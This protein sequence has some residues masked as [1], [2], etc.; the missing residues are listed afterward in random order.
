[1]ESQ[2]SL[3]AWKPKL[4]IKLNMRSFFCP[5]FCATACLLLTISPLEI[6][7]SVAKWVWSSWPC[8]HINPMLNYQLRMLSV[9]WALPSPSSWEHMQIVL[10]RH[11]RCWQQSLGFE[12]DGNIISSVPHVAPQ[13]IILDRDALKGG[14]VLLSISQAGP[15]RNFMQP[16]THLDSDSGLCCDSIP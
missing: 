10:I 15:G 12:M 14:P 3:Q 4:V 1:M 13:G 6:L 5:L 16:R 8:S 9:R 11:E 7:S 2:F